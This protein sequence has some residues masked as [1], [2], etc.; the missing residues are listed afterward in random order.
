MNE[1]H[2]LKFMKQK[3]SQCSDEIVVCKDGQN[4]TL[5]EVFTSLNLTA[6]DLSIDTLD[7]HAHNTFY[8]FD[9]FNLK[10]NPAGQSLLREIFLKTD[11]F[12]KGRYLAELTQEVIAEL[13]VNKYSIVEWRVSI[14]GIGCDEWSK[15]ADWFYTNRLAHENV[16]WMVQVPRLFDSYR[17]KGKLNNFQDMLKNIFDPLFSVTLNPS[18]NIALSYFL[19]TIVGFD[20]VDDE[21]RPEW[22][23]LSSGSSSLPKPGEWVDPVNPPYGYYLY[24][25]YANITAL[26][27]LR[28][29][30]GMNSFQFRPHCGEAG[31]ADHLI[32]AYILANQ[33]NHGIRLRKLPTLQFLFYLSQVGIAMSPL[34]NNKLFLAFNKNPFPVYFKQGLNVSLSTDDPLLLHCTKDPL[35]EEYSVAT[36]VWN[37][38]PTDQCEIARN[39]YSNNIT[40]YVYLVMCF[41]RLCCLCVFICPLYRADKCIVYCVFSVLQSGLED[42]YKRHFLGD[43]YK[44][45]CRTNVP[46]IRLRYI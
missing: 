17:S 14:Y 28:A 24:Y 1:M 42:E 4:M 15:L 25:M 8:R 35:V 20:S 34:S 43:D 16:R 10:Y 45:V 36:Q 41:G 19:D 13:A 30:R 23:N 29:T 5:G 38:S 32:S 7:M 46:L 18:S 27:Q 21:S 33:V 9:R 31:D 39:R 26:N 3:L 12:I 11:N 44:D 40:M 37:F 6:A 2:L 22:G